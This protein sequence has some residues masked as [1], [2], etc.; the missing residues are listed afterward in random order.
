MSYLPTLAKMKHAAKQTELSLH[1]SSEFKMAVMKVNTPRT[2]MAHAI[3]KCKHNKYF[4]LKILTKFGNIK[5][6]KEH[7][8]IPI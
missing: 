6:D 3:Y 7:V 4:F 8:Y 5:F 2:C 1:L